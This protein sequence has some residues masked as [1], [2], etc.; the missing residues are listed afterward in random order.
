MDWGGKSKMYLVRDFFRLRLQP[1]VL[2]WR[3]SRAHRNMHDWRLKQGFHSSLLL[4][5]QFFDNVCIFIVLFIAINFY[6]YILRLS[7]YG[8]FLLY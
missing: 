2:R 4:F 3:G 7:S 5:T 6:I 1:R 8:T